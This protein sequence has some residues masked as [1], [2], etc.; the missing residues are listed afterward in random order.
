M[1]CRDTF[2]QTW[3][4]Y[5]SSLGSIIIQCNRTIWRVHQQTFCLWEE[6]REAGHFHNAIEFFHSIPWVLEQTHQV[7][8]PRV[9]E[10][11]HEGLHS[12]LTSQW[13]LHSWRIMKCFAREVGDKPDLG[14]LPTVLYFSC[15]W[16]NWDP[17]VI[18]SGKDFPPLESFSGGG[19]RLCHLK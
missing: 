6:Q 8:F 19:G 11:P 16:G 4:R 2:S 5:G 7:W 10:M 12:F 17:N 3:N 14:L 13:E 9:S 18:K 15:H 1:T